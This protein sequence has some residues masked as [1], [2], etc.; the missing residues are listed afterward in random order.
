[1]K[2][3]LTH[4][5]FLDEDPKEKKIMRP[6]PPL[7]ILYI[8]S[9]LNE[10]GIENEV[11]DSTFSSKKALLQHIMTTSPDVV[12]IYTNLMTK[13]NIL[14]MIGAIKQSNIKCKVVLG[15]PDVTY[16]T[17]KYLE[18][19][20]DYIVVGE[21]EVTLFELVKALSESTSLEAVDGLAYLDANGE[22]V[23]TKPRTKLRDI[24]ELPI[25]N[26]AAI[27]VEK[28]LQAWRDHHGKSALNVSTQR[29]CPYTCKWCSTAVYGQ[30]YRRRSPKEV[31]KE[32]LDIKEKYNPDSIWFVDDVFT[33]SHK[34]LAEMA[35][36]MEKHDLHI[37]FECITRADRM[38]SDVID[39]LKR[40]GCF[41]VWI[42]AESGSQKIIDAMDR[43]VSVDKVREMIIE[44]RAKGI[45]SGTF[46]M[47]GY[48]GETEEDINETIH[49]LKVSNPDHFT[50]TKAYPIKGTALYSEVEAIST[51]KPA[52]NLSTDRDID[53]ER[54]YR[55]KYY[56]FAIKR[57]VNEVN[58]A[59]QQETLS[60]RKLKLKMKSLLSYFGMQIYKYSS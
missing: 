25:P 60:M 37:P 31:L 56:D 6:Y 26:R 9:Y 46:I 52:W 20:A 19:G 32:L 57:I 40:M 44:A 58:Y 48:P 34:W 29:G 15:G 24:D 2:V 45:E 7:G 50:I 23:K 17:K 28:Y 51:H 54:T 12:A 8:S 47:V 53:F 33:V 4:G 14:E 21:G 35:D 10:Q 16:N 22:E 11:F 55:S 41:R 36:E 27:P 3:L 1:M 43:R 59:K 42:G 18:N 39:I 30:S 13:L 49:H 38:T 5:Y